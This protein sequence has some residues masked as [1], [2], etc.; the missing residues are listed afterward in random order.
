R[1]SEERHSVA[2][3]E[4]YGADKVRKIWNEWARKNL[5]E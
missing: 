1:S 3:I 4:L 2:M 5:E